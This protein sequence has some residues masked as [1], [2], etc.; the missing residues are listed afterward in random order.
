MLRVVRAASGNA[1]RAN[2]AGQYRQR[3]DTARATPRRMS[4]APGLNM[5]FVD[6]VSKDPAAA[7]AANK[8]CAAPLSAGLSSA[9]QP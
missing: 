4:L 5:S 8:Q 2:L 9:P 6:R 1:L 3:A 7:A